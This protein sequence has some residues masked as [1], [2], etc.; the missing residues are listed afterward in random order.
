MSLWNKIDAPEGMFAYIMPSEGEL[1]S[2]KIE[3]YV[4]QKPSDVADFIFLNWNALCKSFAPDACE[5]SKFPADFGE[6]AYI[7][8]ES[9]QAP[10]AVVAIREVVIFHMKL[11][12]PEGQHVLIGTSVDNGEG[13]SGDNVRAECAFLV[14]QCEPCVDDPNRTHVVMSY[15]SDPKGSLPG[16]IKNKI[17]KKRVKLYE[18]MIPQLE[19]LRLS[20]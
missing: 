1:D 6:N 16:A 14:H 19:I 11:A 8:K 10:V 5:N 17:T 18:Q 4:N 13:P 15:Q 3:F 7:Y 9:F 20:S 2:L 12:T